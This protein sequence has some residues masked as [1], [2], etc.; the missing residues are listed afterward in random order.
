VL[1][2]GKHFKVA[3]SLIRERYPDAEIRGLFLA[4]CARE[5]VEFDLESR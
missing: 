5:P 2:S 4:R 3:Q 1:N